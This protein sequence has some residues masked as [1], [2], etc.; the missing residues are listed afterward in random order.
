M[1]RSARL[2]RACCNG[3]AWERR[4][5]P[6]SAALDKVRRGRGSLPSG[7]QRLSRRRTTH[8]SSPNT[9]RPP[10]TAVFVDHVSVMLSRTLQPPIGNFVRDSPLS[11]PMLPRIQYSSGICPCVVCGIQQTR[12][13]EHCGPFPRAH[14]RQRPNFIRNRLSP[15]I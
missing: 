6:S 3:S 9:G 10:E 11:C 5:P 12:N 8:P 7:P 13:S 4:A 14:S 1:P 15:V 2:F